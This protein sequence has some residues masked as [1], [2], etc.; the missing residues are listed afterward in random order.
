LEL[1]RTSTSI[2]LPKTNANSRGRRRK[3]SKR[4]NVRNWEF[5]CYEKYNGFE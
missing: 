5:T 3:W 4:K 2:K 1:T